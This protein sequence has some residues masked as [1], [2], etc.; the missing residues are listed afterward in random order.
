MLGERLAGA[1]SDNDVPHTSRFQIQPVRRI[2]DPALLKRRLG[3]C[4]RVRKAYIAAASE[5][6][7]DSEKSPTE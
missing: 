4:A 5:S 3:G 2:A 7:S 1:C 6:E